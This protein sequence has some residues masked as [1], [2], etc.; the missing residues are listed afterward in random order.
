[1]NKPRHHTRLFAIVDQRTLVAE[2]KHAIKK[3]GDGNLSAAARLARMNQPE[4]HRLAKGQI[5]AIGRNTIAALRR[6]IP[7]ERHHLL[8]QSLISPETAELLSAFDEWR[9]RW[10][11]RFLWPKSLGDTYVGRAVQ[12]VSEWDK[13]RLFEVEHLLRKCRQEFPEQFEKFDSFLVRQGHSRTRADMAL[14]RIVEP[15]LESRASGFVERSWEELEISELRKFIESG[16]AREKIL[17][18]RSPDTQR[19]QQ[20]AGRNP[21]DLVRLYGQLW[22][23]R[24]FMG[25]RTHP[26]I[27]EYIQ[28]LLMKKR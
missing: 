28:S 24:A 22:D 17:L 8:E 14:Y 26:L 18:R 12:S 21:V 16:I 9:Q 11:E 7:P 5:G 13:Q 23:V 2:I 19:A 10:E 20:Q 6:L 1:M 4:L 3:R 25:R 15:L 27:Q